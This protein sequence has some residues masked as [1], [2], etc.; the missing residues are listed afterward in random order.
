MYTHVPLVL[1]NDQYSRTS[2]GDAEPNCSAADRRA[3]PQMKAC[4]DSRRCAKLLG[5]K[6]RDTRTRKAKESGTR[7]IIDTGPL[8]HG[9]VRSSFYVI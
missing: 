1:L 8:A 5:A 3:Q 7:N 6:L 9:R 2:D 4:W